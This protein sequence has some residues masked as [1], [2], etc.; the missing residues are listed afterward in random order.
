MDLNLFFADLASEKPVPGGGSASA[1]AAAMS[2]SL[3]EMVA[4]LSKGKTDE[5]DLEGRFQE[6]TAEVKHLASELLLLAEDDAKGYDTVIQAFHL[7]KNSEKEKDTR[8]QAIQDAFKGAIAPPLALMKKALSLL[9]FTEFTLRKGNPNAFSDAGVAFYLAGV[10][11]NGGKMNVLINLG[12]LKDVSFKV[13]CRNEVRQ[14]EERFE[15]MKKR[16]EIIIRDWMAA[17]MD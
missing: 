8:G 9:E 13:S 4:S 12:S 10:A 17:C 14:L 6:I 3:L 5:K 11:F 1:V 15:T 2:A 7:P 16:I